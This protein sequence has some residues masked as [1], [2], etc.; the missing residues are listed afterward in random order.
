M[1]IELSAGSFVNLDRLTAVR[2]G[3]GDGELTV[4]CETAGSLSRRHE[5]AEALA[6]QALCCHRTSEE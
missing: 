3:T 1:W 4:S 2:F 5:G 6:L